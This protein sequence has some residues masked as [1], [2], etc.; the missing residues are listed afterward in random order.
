MVNNPTTSTRRSSRVVGNFH[1][2]VGSG[3]GVM[4]GGD[5]DLL[6]LL[7]GSTGLS[8][9][10]LLGLALLQEGL[11]DHDLVGGGDRAVGG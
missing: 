6:L 2:I 8:A 7:S 3:V 11:G 4:G 1:Q 10:S 9:G 5:T